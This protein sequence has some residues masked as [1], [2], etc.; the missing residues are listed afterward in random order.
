MVYLKEQLKKI[1]L[2]QNNISIEIAD[3]IL[4]PLDEIEVGQKIT[5]YIEPYFYFRVT[6]TILEIQRDYETSTA[7]LSVGKTLY[8]QNKPVTINY[9]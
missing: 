1:S 6:T 7:K 2:P 3:S 5:I 4:A 9:K 8:K